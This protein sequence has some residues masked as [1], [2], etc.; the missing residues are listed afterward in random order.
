MG[1]GLEKNQGVDAVSAGERSCM[2]EEQGGGGGVV[3]YNS[4][5]GF[6]KGGLHAQYIPP[7]LKTTLQKRIHYWV[8]Q[9]QIIM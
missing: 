9:L 1:H 3:R 2:E 6:S 7:I 4:S 8:T 5:P